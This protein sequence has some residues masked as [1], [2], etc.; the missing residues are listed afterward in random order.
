MVGN[1][2]ESAKVMFT[3]DEIRLVDETY[4]QKKTTCKLH[5]L[6]D[7]EKCS[8]ALSSD[9]LAGGCVR[10]SQQSAEISVYCIPFRKKA[11]AVSL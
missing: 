6:V 1:Q 2:Y 11:T 10:G 9:R 5:E 4:A 8:D 3:N 7:S